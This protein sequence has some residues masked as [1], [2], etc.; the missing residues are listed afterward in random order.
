[1]AKCSHD[2]FVEFVNN[3]WPFL[4][5][6]CFPRRHTLS[7]LTKGISRLPLSLMFKTPQRLM[8]CFSVLGLILL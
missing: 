3:Q 2:N 4:K 6:K 8:C 1:M 5:K 7:W